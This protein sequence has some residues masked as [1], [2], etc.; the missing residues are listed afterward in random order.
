MTAQRYLLAGIVSAAIGNALVAGVFLTFSSFVMPALA[1]IAPASAVAAMQSINIVVVPSLFIK[2]YLLTT[3]VSGLLI[4]T[5]AFSGSDLTTWLSCIAGVVAIA[6]SFGVTML[7][8][9]PLNN[10]LAIATPESHA[11][12]LQWSE[13]VRDWGA[14]NL[15][16]TLASTMASLIFFGAALRLVAKS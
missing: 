3:I 16:R 1:R 5:P 4:F 10:A 8:N 7:L 12:A 14:A 13:Y 6:G 9:V 11:T 15:A 2:I